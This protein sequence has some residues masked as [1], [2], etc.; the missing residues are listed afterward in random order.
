MSRILKIDHQFEN[1]FVVF[2]EKMGPLVE[3]SFNGREANSE[4]QNRDR[5]TLTNS[6]L[7]ETTLPQA[8]IKS[9][10]ILCIYVFHECV[11]LNE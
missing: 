6:S 7:L 4:R 11:F 1:Q 2:G 10:H 8:Q 9:K 5:S 3:Q